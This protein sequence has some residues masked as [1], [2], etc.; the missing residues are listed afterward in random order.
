MKLMPRKSRVLVVTIAISIAMVM[1]M[2]PTTDVAA[3]AV[4]A[5]RTGT[6]SPLPPVHDST[7]TSKNFPTDKRHTPSLFPFD[8]RFLSTTTALSAT[9]PVQLLPGPFVAAAV[10]PTCIGLWRTGFAVSFGYGGAMLASGVIQ[11]SASLRR[12]SEAML[13]LKLHA[14]IYVFYGARLCGFLFH[15]QKKSVLGG[16]KC[17]DATLAERLKGLPII[18]GC[19]GL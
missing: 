7:T 4:N 12:S 16:M 1:A 11:L 18:L 3:F 2:V 19:S 15:R 9:V 17:R 13:P 6:S 10:I 8:R 14:V 5:Q